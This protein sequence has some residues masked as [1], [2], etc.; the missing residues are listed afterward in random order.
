MALG[1]LAAPGKSACFAPPR[2]LRFGCRRGICANCISFYCRWQLLSAL[3]A[4]TPGPNAVAVDT[5]EVEAEVVVVDSTVEAVASMAVPAEASEVAMAAAF[6]EAW[7]VASEAAMAAGDMDAVMATGAV[8]A[9]D[10]A[11][12]GGRGPIGP[13]RIMAITEDG[14]IPIIRTIQTTPIIPTTRPTRAIPMAHTTVVFQATGQF[15]LHPA[16]LLPDKTRQ[17]IPRGIL[18]RNPIPKRPLHR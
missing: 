18:H 5:A 17:S 15:L 8:G 3:P 2:V 13:E 10:M 9:V 11:S 4:L 16:P 14:G 12:A 7:V 1:L 6:A